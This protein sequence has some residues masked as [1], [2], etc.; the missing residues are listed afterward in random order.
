MHPGCTFRKTG[1]SEERA[2]HT[3]QYTHNGT[4]LCTEV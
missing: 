1:P 3:T 4:R 2:D